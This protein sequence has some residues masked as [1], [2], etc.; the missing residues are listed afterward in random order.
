MLFLRM[1]YYSCQKQNFAVIN[2]VQGIGL[3]SLQG[4]LLQQRQQ[5]W[6]WPQ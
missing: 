4:E 2:K 6:I 5:G 1:G 3:I